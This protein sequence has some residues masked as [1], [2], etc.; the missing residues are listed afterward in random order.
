VDLARSAGDHAAKREL[1]KR[2]HE[3]E[4]HLELSLKMVAMFAERDVLG[5]RV[6]VEV[7]V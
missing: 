6:P 4:K 7:A 5:R 1:A 2:L 3:E